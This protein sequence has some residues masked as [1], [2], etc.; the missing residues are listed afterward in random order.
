MDDPICSGRSSPA[1]TSLMATCLDWALA[2]G[3]P[4]PEPWLAYLERTTARPSHARAVAA[5]A[6]P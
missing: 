4:L 3:V 6:V 5:N 1:L 2:Y